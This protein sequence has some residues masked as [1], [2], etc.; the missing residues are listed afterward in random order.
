MT[1]VLH[2]GAG[3]LGRGLI[4]PRIAAAGNVVRVADTDPAVV[5]AIRNDHGYPL[6]IAEPGA[7]DCR[8]VPIDGTYVIGRDDA[9]L[10]AIIAGS[11]L[12][13]TSVR[14]PNLPNVVERL[15]RVWRAA[16]PRRRVVIG[17]EN[18][19]KVG[20]HISALFG[21]ALEFEL[22]APD[23]VVDRICA[24]QPDSLRIEAER[25]TE[26]VIEGPPQAGAD[27]AADVDRLFFRKRY[28]VNTLADGAAFLGLARGH[29]YLHQA[30][31]DAGIIA[32]LMPLVVLLEQ[33]L[34]R[35]F[36][37]AA[38]ELE[39]YRRLSLARL[40]NAAI[41]R[42]LETVARDAWRKFG[43]DERFVE[44]ILAEA[45][46]GRDV[47]AA[48]GVLAR[49]IVAAEPDIDEIA[50]HL[51]RSWEGAAAELIEPMRRALAEAS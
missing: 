42:R 12:V 45:R 34:E 11:D 22:A 18:M 43:A 30:I 32:T 9:A 7:V 38:P 5:D 26:W 2:F 47:S 39:D 21:S 19:R 3:A 24:T 16:P 17:C 36:G 8:F 23:C 46:A 1:T 35:A 44:P 51:A 50:A 40:G 25:Y 4:L 48:L 14:L 27:G 41:S 37:F 31:G 13:T 6:D 33:H 29:R 10:D 28:L 20:A 15:K 49:I